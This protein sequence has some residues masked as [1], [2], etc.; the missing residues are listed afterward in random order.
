MDRECV[1]FEETQLCLSAI[2]TRQTRQ[3]MEED[4]GG[5]TRSSVPFNLLVRSFH[6]QTDASHVIQKIQKIHNSIYFRFLLSNTLKK[7]NWKT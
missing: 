2:Y 6:I 1:C 5:V 3:T 4:F 7:K